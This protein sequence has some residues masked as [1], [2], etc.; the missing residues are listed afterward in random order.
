MHIIGQPKSIHDLEPVTEEELKALAGFLD[1]QIK[2]GVDVRMPQAI[3]IQD[4]GRLMV[5]ALSYKKQADEAVKSEEEQPRLQVP[6]TD[7]GTS[8]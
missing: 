8:S 7:W 1:E 2:Q 4:L 6:P 3:S 5:T